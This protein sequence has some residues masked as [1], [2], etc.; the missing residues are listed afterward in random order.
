MTK[1]RLQQKLL[2]QKIIACELSLKRVVKF[3]VVLYCNQLLV[4]HFTVLHISWVGLQ[5]V[6]VV[7]SDHTHLIFGS[8]IKYKTLCLK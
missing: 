1:L 6:I 8:S 3:S 7:F 4:N 2:K 5:C